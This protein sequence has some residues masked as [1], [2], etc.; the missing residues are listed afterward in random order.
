MRNAFTQKRRWLF[1]LLIVQLLNMSIDPPDRLMYLNS[2][3]EAR[4]GYNEI[5]SVLELVI[6]LQE[7]WENAIPENNDAEQ[8]TNRVLAFPLFLPGGQAVCLFAFR[9][10]ISL[11]GHE[12]LPCSF[13]RELITPPPEA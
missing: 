10:D 12:Q 7:G 4:S 5:E 2:A 13:S 1:W 6:E 8:E 3:A 9:Q 11:T